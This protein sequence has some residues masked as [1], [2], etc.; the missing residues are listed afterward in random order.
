MLGPLV[1]STSAT[2]PGMKINH[3]LIPLSLPFLLVA[4]GYQGDPERFANANA[5]ELQKVASEL[6]ETA[7]I[8]RESAEELRLAAAEVREGARYRP[9]ASDAAPTPPTQGENSDAS[10]EDE[11]TAFLSAIGIACDLLDELFLNIPSDL[12]FPIAMSALEKSDAKSAEAAEASI[13]PIVGECMV[14]DKQ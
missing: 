12:C 4:C 8:M 1:R 6:R 13:M 10:D 9:A 5:E 2:D 7:A 11:K 14:K 3:R